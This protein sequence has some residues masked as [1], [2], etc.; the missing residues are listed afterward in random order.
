VGKLKKRNKRWWL[1]GCT[2]GRYV[3][4]KKKMLEKEKSEPKHGKVV[5][6]LKMST[7]G[8]KWPSCNKKKASS[9][10]EGGPKG[11]PSGRLES[12]RKSVLEIQREGGQQRR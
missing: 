9:S 8:E 11:N 12:K 2:T 6:G 7:G 1:T 3:T 4:N 5:P 10:I